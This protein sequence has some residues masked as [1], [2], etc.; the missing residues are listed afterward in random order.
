MRYPILENNE[1]KI[2]R[3]AISPSEPLSLHRHS[4][5]R[6]VVP[7]KDVSLKKVVEGSGRTEDIH[8]SFRQAYWIEADPPNELHEL[9]ADLN[10][11]DEEM[12]VIVIEFKN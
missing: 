8:F 5:K 6:I 3:T 2:W 4:K 9:H 11:S 7:L 1:V 12:E 10:V